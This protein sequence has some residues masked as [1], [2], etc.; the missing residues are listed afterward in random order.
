M[1][2]NLRCDQTIGDLSCYF[3]VEIGSYTASDQE[4]NLFRHHRNDIG[5][6]LGG[7]LGVC[8]PSLAMTN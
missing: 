2:Q 1:L 5:A 7:A 4:A 8:A 6:D 3:T